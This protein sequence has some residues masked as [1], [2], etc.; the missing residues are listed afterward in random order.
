MLENNK[1]EI[2]IGI[3]FGIVNSC[4]GV[5]IN[6]EIKEQLIEKFKIKQN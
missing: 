2:R 5:Y 6:E 1:T 4:S 3:D